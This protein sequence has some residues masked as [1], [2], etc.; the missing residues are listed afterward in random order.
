MNVDQIYQ[1]QRDDAFAAQFSAE[2]YQTFVAMPFSNRGGYPEP[3]IKKLLLGKVHE[4]A[5]EIIA[6]GGNRRT[7]A[8]LTR[9]DGGPS[10]AV[11]I[12][13]QIVNRILDCHFF[14]GDLTGCNFGVVL[15]TGIALALKPNGRVLLFTQDD[16]ASLHFDL[17]VTNV[18]RYEER[19]LVDRAARALAG[20]ADAFEREADLY[21]RH[22]SSR[23]T[24]EAIGLLNYY[25]QLWWGWSIGSPTPSLHFGQLRDKPPFDQPDGWI[26]FNAAVRELIAARLL[27]TDYQSNVGAGT[28]AFGMHATKLGWRVIEHI[29]QHESRMKQPEGAPTG[30][31]LT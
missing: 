20:A 3:R 30:P 22:V 25:G 27:W 26:V 4:K 28:D 13:D 29:W 23:L 18:N 5:N 15:E 6:A 7:F 14:L 31:N 17:K 12:T 19:N 11:V 2:H 1:L 9:V 24:P 21:I 16:T 10:G 8:P